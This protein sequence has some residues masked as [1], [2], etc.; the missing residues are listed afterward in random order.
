MP[1]LRIL[2]ASEQVASHLRK[3]LLRGKRIG[4][5]PGEQR[6]VKELGVGRDTV[7]EALRLLEKEGLLLT[8]GKGRRRRI[9]L[10]ESGV[11]PEGMRVGV[12]LFEPADRESAFVAELRHRLADSGHSVVLA[13][14]SL[15]ELNK[16][17]KRVARMVG[18]TPADAWI[19]FAGSENVLEWF[20]E[21]PFPVIAYAGQYP[22]D[23]KVAGVAPRRRDAMTEVVRRLFSLGHRRMV[24]LAGSG[25]KPRPFLDGLEAH[26]IATGPYNIP[27]WEFS[28]DGLRRC[29]DALF[30]TTPPTALLVD[31]VFVF[32]IVE[33]YL[34]RRGFFAPE[35]ISLVSLDPD[36]IF[37]W[38]EPGIAHISWNSSYVIRRIERWVMN[39]SQGKE[40]S[41]QTGVK[42]KFVDGG[43]IGPAPG[44]R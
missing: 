18:A 42:A 20:G 39:V 40:D 10:P 30:A 3:E 35:H 31:E 23:M 26:G 28:P 14:K 44:G 32:H 34:A 41:R 16:D 24:L 5:M 38:Y 2:S 29:L 25:A 8:Q 12:L 22:R 19:V 15:V 11:K 9:A 36:P 37:D 43:T 21:Q 1:K 7:K 17:V 27:D 33:R 13:H 4:V 6:L